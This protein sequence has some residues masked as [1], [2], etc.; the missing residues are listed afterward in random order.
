MGQKLSVDAITNFI[1]DVVTVTVG[2]IIVLQIARFARLD[3]RPTRKRFQC[4]PQRL[5]EY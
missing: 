3:R 1:F 4:H 5:L 2:G